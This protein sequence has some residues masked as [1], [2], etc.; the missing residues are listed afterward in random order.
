MTPT[1]EV[2]QV[3]ELMHCTAGFSSDELFDKVQLVEDR[4]QF[5]TMLA[6]LSAEKAIDRLK[7]AEGM[8]YWAKGRAPADAH[9]STPTTAPAPRDEPPASLPFRLP[10]TKP[11]APVKTAPIRAPD[12]AGVQPRLTR[13]DRGV[14]AVT[15]WPGRT[16]PELAALE[17]GFKGPTNAS[18]TLGTCERRGLLARKRWPPET[19]YRYYLPGQ[20]PETRDATPKPAAKARAATIEPEVAPAQPRSRRP[21]LLP[22]EPTPAPVAASGSPQ[23]VAGFTFEPIPPRA[24]DPAS[25]QGR[26]LAAMSAMPVGMCIVVKE[27]THK[28]RHSEFGRVKK[29]LPEKTFFSEAVG[30]TLRIGRT[31]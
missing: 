23:V 11:A 29:M 14:A 19:G 26:M 18:E 5:N 12:G 2:I 6:G 28:G 27:S 13:L 4:R 21:P 17:P 31:A 10:L 7:L 30:E 16:P 1:Q 20:V 25:L 8:R 22:R 3:L 9:V 24:P 15:K